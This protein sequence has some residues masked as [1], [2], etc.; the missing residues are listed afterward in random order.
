MAADLRAL[1]AVG[2]AHPDVRHALQV[3]RGAEPGLLLI[4]GLW[5]HR[6]VLD[7]GIAV[8]SF[9]CTPELLYSDE[10]RGLAE[11]VAT[12]SGVAYQVS[13]KT[14]GRLS[15]SHRSVDG[16]ASVIR[17]PQ[18]HRDEV[19]L[20]AEPL[21]VV[22]DGLASPGNLGTVIR[23]MDACGADLL[24]MTGTRARTSAGTVFKGSRGR[25]LT[26]PH[27]T[28]ESPAEAA[29]WLRSRSIAIKIADADGSVA[30]T[31]ADWSGPTA[32]V[33]GN[34]HSGPSQAWRGFDRVRI[35][36]L[37]HADSLNVAVSAGVLLFHARF[38]RDR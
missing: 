10:G 24:I 21:V 32:I 17:M 25:T 37:G 3:G 7:A 5:A 16:I 20:G 1:R 2:A 14:I 27:I 12:R 19:A 6:A 31:A 35:P 9:F 33:L 4:S 29:A 26:V 36:M 38:Q 13:E 22:A 15:D 11:V 28:I 18:W 8:E 30:Y 34:E 23:T